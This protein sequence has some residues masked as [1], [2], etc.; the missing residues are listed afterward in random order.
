MILTF[1]YPLLGLTLG[2][3]L[4]EETGC[5]SLWSYI[6]I[7]VSLLVW[8]SFYLVSKDPIKSFAFSKFQWIWIFSLFVG[9][10]VLD[11][12]LNRLNSLNDNIFNE[13]YCKVTGVVENIKAKTT[14]DQII[15]YV[16][17]I[18]SPHFSITSG[19]IR[20]LVKT[21]G[22]S[23]SNGDLISCTGVL[24]TFPNNTKKESDYAKFM[25]RQKIEA[26]M[27][28][29]SDN[30]ELI[31]RS[32]HWKYNLAKLKENTQIL[33]DKSSIKKDTGNF[34]ISILMGDKSFLNPHDKEIITNAG[35]AHV[36]ALSG[37]HVAII[38][39][40]MMLLL[41]PLAL[42]GHNNLRRILAIVVIWAYVAF[43]GFSFSTIRAA[44]MLTLVVWAITIE[45]KNSPLNALFA[46]S[47][48]IIL[49]DP[50][51]IYDIGFQLSFLCVA[52]II[53]FVERLNPIQ[54]HTHPRLYKVVNLSLVSLSVTFVS[55]IIVMYYFKQVPLLFLPSNLILLPLLPLYLGIAILY[56]GF[57]A[58]H[59][60]LKFLSLFLDKGYEL[61]LKASS[62]LS[63]NGSGIIS[64]NIEP[65]II[66]LWVSG[67][68]F[69]ALFL[70]SSTKRR[71]YAFCAT[72][73]LILSVL[74]IVHAQYNEET[75]KITFH[76][77]FTSINV[78][79]ENN[80]KIDKLVFPRRTL[81]RAI[82]PSYSIFAIDCPFTSDFPDLNEVENEIR[83]VF[84]VV[85]PG[86]DNEQI[87]QLTEKLNFR[88]IILHSNIGEKQETL[89][90]SLLNP[91]NSSLI[92]SLRNEGSLEFEL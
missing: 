86:A 90:R 48:I 83:N 35:L 23:L 9:V 1:L 79:V 77:S 15:L 36:L 21:D 4:C 11:V 12:N 51:S 24:R 5:S 72:G 54:H 3:L 60:D 55:W 6:L 53:L 16:D 31:G 20:V 34:L 66:F 39:V 76:H 40:I 57:L 75:T 46:A 32:L 30:I 71:G 78:S 33:I 73:C 26:Y 7:G 67:I 91:Q 38:F 42:F 87:A 58:F 8:L 56:I 28:V 80:E 43:T 10:G 68:I 65:H 52:A 29:R 37:L 47:F 82:T 22:V 13:N 27:N 44:I 62:L 61:F 84:L 70:Y 89:L 41:F 2:V 17:S 45:R 49:I 18:S 85:G 64:L 74:A 81:S 69:I 19:N 59:L 14:G 25:H 50:L 92:H 88:R 63:G